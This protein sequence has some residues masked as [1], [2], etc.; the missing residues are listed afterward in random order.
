MTHRVETLPSSF[1]EECFDE[2]S[3]EKKYQLSQEITEHSHA[4][5]L[6]PKFMV[7]I[8]RTRV[9]FLIWSPL[10]HA[11]L[12]DFDALLLP[13]GVMNPDALRIIPKAIEFIKKK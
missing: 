5:D 6:N 7:G 9:V 3:Y 11:N 8:M 1:R 13:G 4:L 2:H 10:R 12:N